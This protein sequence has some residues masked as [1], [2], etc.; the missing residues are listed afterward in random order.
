MACSSPVK[1]DNGLDAV[2]ETYVTDIRERS[3]LL[4]SKEQKMRIKV[5]SLGLV[6]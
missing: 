1:S 4:K 6:G 2:F 3:A 5:R